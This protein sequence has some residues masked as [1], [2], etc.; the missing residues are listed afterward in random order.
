MPPPDPALWREAQPVLDQVLDAPESERRRILARVA[1][2]RPAL[3][4]FVERLL[5]GD[6]DSITTLA[7]VGL[8]R[9]LEERPTLG[10]QRVGPYRLERLLGEGGMGAVWLGRRADGD[11][12]GDGDGDVAI[13]LLHL[14]TLRP[15]RTER[16]RREAALLARLDH[17]NVARLHDA[18]V[19]SAGQPYLV[20]EYVDGLRL[21]HY[22]SGRRLRLEERLRLFLQLCSAVGAVH[23]S[24]IVHRDLKPPN[25]LVTPDARVKLLDFG[26]ARLVDEDG[27]V[28]AASTTVALTPEF[29][30]PEQVHG[31]ALT[32]A[33]DVYALG[34][35]LHLL[36][37]GRHPTG[38][39]ARTPADFIR[40]TLERSPMLPSAAVVPSE[41]W[42][43]DDA[44]R[45]AAG[46]GI[47]PAALR[48]QLS[49]SLDA[50]V[51][52]ALRKEPAG[53]HAGVAE[54]A[55]D[56]ER[57]L[58]HEPGPHLTP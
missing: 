53:R 50:I 11:A 25:V 19:T 4:Q 47:S 17:P 55:A 21:D 3:A 42:P 18:G 5:A 38:W 29:A 46:L 24:L 56:L 12:A 16:F 57:H 54:L 36:L 40:T 34:L 43:A 39:D 26:I 23:A 2:E 14:G 30:A 8:E 9:V 22:C 35:L 27:S 49:G 10:G 1:S 28:S 45:H 44:D 20:L 32:T 7:A 33:V 15:G 6:D 37:T 52:K 41:G 51:G 58:G 31:V 48:D 13:K